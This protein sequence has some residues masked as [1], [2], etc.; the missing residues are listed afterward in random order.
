MG[1]SALTE[2]LLCRILR[3]P[4]ELTASHCPVK[5]TFLRHREEAWSSKAVRWEQMNGFLEKKIRPHSVDWIGMLQK[6]GN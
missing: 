6:S 4:C 5:R 3:T 2:M 1:A